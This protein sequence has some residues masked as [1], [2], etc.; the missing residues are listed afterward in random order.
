MN[1]KITYL[2][3]IILFLA[4]TA[5]IIARYKTRAGNNE[6][7]YFELQERKGALALSPEWDKT[8]NTARNLFR[9]VA[10]NPGDTKSVLG[11][12]ALFIKEAR[13]TGNYSYYDMAALKQVDNVLKQDP[14]NF[15]ALT[16]KALIYLSQHHFAEGLELATKAQKLNPYNALVHGMLIDA[17]V[18][19]GKYG[20]AVTNADKMVSLRPDLPSYSRISYLREIH[21]DYPGAIEAMKMAVEAGLPGEDGTEWTRVQL[22]HLYEN[23]G[24]LD[25]AEYEYAQSL[26]YRKGYAPAIAGLGHI[27]FVTGD[28]QRSISYYKEADTL[29]TDYTTKENLAELYRLTGQQQKSDSLYSWII[30]AMSKDADGANKNETIGHYVD[31][32]LAHAYL[33]VGDNDKAL[34]H[35]LAE[36]NR[37]PNNIDINETVA[38]VYYKKNDFQKAITYMD[39]ALKTNCKNPTLLCHAGL[40][41]AK[42]GD[43]T[44]AKQILIEALKRNPGIDI[45]LK[46]ESETMLATL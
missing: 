37:R 31:R 24:K 36:Y 16:Y 7:S 13:I 25:S 32:E 38:W 41:Y 12:A 18:E 33:T 26:I 8:R 27:G 17:N 28:Y 5:F 29:I 44:K 1:K 11:L 21:G 20:D 9:S 39:T 23:T 34:E 15:M 40:V 43:K 45:E 2:F 4:G 19:L 35:A 14:N 30:N 3:L 10:E 46:K 22:G 42:G 6:I